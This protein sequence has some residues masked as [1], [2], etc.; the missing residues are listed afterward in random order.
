LPAAAFSFLDN[1]ETLSFWPSRAPLDTS[2]ASEQGNIHMNNEVAKLVE[3]LQIFNENIFD[4]AGA[5]TSS[6]KLF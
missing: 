3:N 4:C 2:T 1:L 6:S 5:I